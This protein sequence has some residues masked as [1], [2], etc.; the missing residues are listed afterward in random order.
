MS[1]RRYL[2]AIGP[3]AGSVDTIQSAVSS[4]CVRDTPNGASG[5]DKQQV[6]PN[7]RGAPVRM[8]RQNYFGGGN[9]AR[10]LTSRQSGRRDRQTGARFHLD[11]REQAVLLHHQ[12]DLTGGRSK[13]PRQHAPP[14]PFK[15]QLGGSFRE[16]TSSISP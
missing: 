16:P 11:N 14:F 13:P 2:T 7:A 10:L 5:I 8:G 15:R 4:E 9:Q 6:E 3:T 1:P 12:V